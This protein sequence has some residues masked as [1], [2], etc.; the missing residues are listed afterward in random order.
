MK[1]S[2]DYL[3]C[4][5]EDTRTQKIVGTGSLILE[6]KFIHECAL[7]GKIEEVV[8]DNTYRGRELGKL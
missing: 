2:Q 1:A 8:V 3:I 7:K 6:Q 4:V 5:I